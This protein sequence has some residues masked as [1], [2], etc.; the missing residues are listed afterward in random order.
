MILGIKG[1]LSGK[2]LCYD[3]KTGSTHQIQIT[4]N[5]LLINEIKNRSLKQ[6]TAILCYSNI[7]EITAEEGL[8]KANVI[9]L[10]VREWDEKPTIELDHYQQIP[11][12]TLSEN[13]HK[14]NT[15]SEIVVFCKSG[16]RS[17]KA[18]NIL[19][20]NNLRSCYN[21]KGG[22]AAL[23]GELKHKLI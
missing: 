21:L 11:L 8:R 7:Q 20:Q 4:K 12:S 18:I 9:F 5:D 13:L 14:I 19:T 17:K 3:G 15:E 2:L 1:V 16:Q 6:E 23:V 10:D 22:A